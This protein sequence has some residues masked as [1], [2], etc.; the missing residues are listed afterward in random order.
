MASPLLFSICAFLMILIAMCGIAYRILYKP[1]KFLKQLGNPVITGQVQQLIDNDA[2]PQASTIVT[3]LH[4]IG[5]KVPSSETEIATLRAN[6]IRGGFRSENAVPVFFGLRIVATLGMLFLVILMEPKMPPNPMMKMALMVSGCSA[7]WILPRF[8]L[9]KRVA[10]RQE[11]LRLSLPDA[12]D[13]MVVSVEAGLGLDQAISHVA[14]ELQGSHPQLSEEMSLVMLEMRAGKRRS[15]A[16]RNFAERTGEDEIRK[17]VAILIQND[18][19]GTSMGESLRTHSD[20]M[21]VA[22]RQEAEER[23]GK[24]GVKLVFPIFFFILPSMLIVAAGP[25]ILQI[26]KYLFPMMKHVGS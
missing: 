24:V 9:E 5:S 3:V 19:F 25:G 13:L 10:K 22:R 26:F 2:E 14:K 16:L 4:Q 1:G 23:A 21:R 20:F 8:I 11:I 15:D 17:L 12:L 6:L 7:G 18:R